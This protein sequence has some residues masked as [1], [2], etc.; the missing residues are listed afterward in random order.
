MGMTGLSDK[1]KQ[2]AMMSDST[3][4]SD[5]YLS[6]KNTIIDGIENNQTRID[7]S[8]F[9]LNREDFDQIYGNILMSQPYLLNLDHGKYIYTY[10]DDPNDVNAVCPRYVG[11]DNEQ[12]EKMKDAMDNAVEK[13]LAQT[14]SAKNDFE[15]VVAIHDYLTHI[16]SYDREASNDPNTAENQ[17]SFS[18]YGI[19]VNEKG[20]CSGYTS[21]FKLIMDK[22]EINCIPAISTPLTHAWALVEIDGNWYNCDL[23][24]DSS[25]KSSKSSS[26]YGFLKSDTYMINLGYNKWKV[27]GITPNAISKTYDVWQNIATNTKAITG[28]VNGSS[29]LIINNKSASLLYDKTKL[30][31]K[32]TQSKNKSVATYSITTLQKGQAFMSIVD[33]NK[34]SN[35]LFST[36]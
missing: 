10:L 14:S 35:V 24:M 8:S 32:L 4:S 19:L 20:V 18:A 31:V 36:N 23:S 34:Y 2:I 25:G 22:L 30:S 7:L 28:K 1:E 17:L 11:Y 33:K 26:H 13:A 16:A 5:T 6:V 12:L 15:K 29:Q 3:M 21:A 9:K 27:P